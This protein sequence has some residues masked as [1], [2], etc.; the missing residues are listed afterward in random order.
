MAVPTNI[1]VLVPR[2][3]RAVEGPVPL[4]APASDN[5]IKDIVADALA[6]V[7]LYTG[8]AFGKQLNVTVIDTVT[9]APT[10][11]ETNDALSLGEGSVIAAQAALNFYFFRLVATKSEERITDEAGEWQTRTSPTLL[12]DA[13]KALQDAR[14]KALLALEHSHPL[15]SYVSFLA[16]RDAEV[17]R[18][19][20]PW[21]LP[22]PGGYFQ[23]R[24]GIVLEPDMRFGG[25]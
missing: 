1:R 10:E 17:S 21:G 6:D 14:D 12:R 22:E 24:V 7:I 3:R 8:S 4:L 13:L 25:F 19:V 11:Y 2:V 5:V 15:E 16:V 23:G 9:G 18:C 20:E